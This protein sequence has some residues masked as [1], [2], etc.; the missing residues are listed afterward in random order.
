MARQH[1]VANSG[2]G[3]QSSV[4][5]AGS[6]EDPHVGLNIPGGPVVPGPRITEDD[7]FEPTIVR[8]RE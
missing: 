8:G 3:A 7:E 1:S 2:P 6:M 5:R 4:L